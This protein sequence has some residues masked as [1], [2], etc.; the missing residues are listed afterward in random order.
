MNIF[1]IILSPFV[2]VLSFLLIVISGEQ[3]GGFYFVYLSRALPHGTLYVIL[4]I[5]GILILLLNLIKPI[6]NNPFFKSI[7]N[8]VG[9]LSL[10]MSVYVFFF[11]DSTEYNLN[12]FSQVVPLITI[13]VFLLLVC[14]F[15]YINFVFLLR[16][17]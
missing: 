11:S 9:G 3:V 7:I 4:A 12:T 5:A 16:R 13:L 6:W 17:K 10:L 15:I 2:I 1:R 8:Q 14:G